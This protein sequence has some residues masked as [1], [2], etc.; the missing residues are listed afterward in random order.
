VE[1]TQNAFTRHYE[2]G[3]EI[4][5][6][7]AHGEGNYYADEATLDRLEGEGRVVFRYKDNPNGS[8]RDIAGILSEKRNVLGL[9]P[10][11]ERVVDSAT[12]GIDGRAL[13]Q[14]LIEALL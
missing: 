8:A 9:M 13:F 4:V 1:E 7:V 11:P 3:Q 12:G 6:P 5:A 10:H 2:K 14:S